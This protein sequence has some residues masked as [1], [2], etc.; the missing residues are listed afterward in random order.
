M[1][2]PVPA[3]LKPSWRGWLHTGMAPLV[4]IAGVILV[5]TAPSQGAKVTTVIYAVTG[6]MLFG[7]SALYHRG[8]W[9]PR[10]R[11][12]LKR[13][14]HSNIMLVIA[15]TY[16]PLSALMLPRPTA[17][18]LLW[19]IWSGAVGGVL[20]RVLWVGAPRWLYVPLYVLL[21]VTAVFFLPQ[22]WAAGALPT[23]LICLGGM[24]YIAGAVVYGMK[25]PTL[26]A[27]H[28]G[29]HEL[30]HALTVAGFAAHFAAV[31]LVVFA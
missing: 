16:T 1:T 31:V 12:L 25:K 18:L 24:F 2:S 4:L 23:L 11:M 29:F 3:E 13:L 17:A 27:Q 10:A 30:F 19:L 22:F 9:R 7:T 15:G 26:S 21:G 28:F 6:V 20:F 5:L 14:D 8:N